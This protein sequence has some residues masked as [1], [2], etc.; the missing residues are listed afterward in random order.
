[1]L[2]AEHLADQAL[3]K[4]PFYYHAKFAALLWLQLPQTRGAAYLYNRFYKP[5]LVQ[6]GPHIDAVLAKG[7]NLLANLYAMYKVPIE[8]AV[9]LG[10][11]AW[12]SLVAAVKALSEEKKAAGDKKGDAVKPHAA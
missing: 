9:A 5:A 2:L 10:L 8:A 1:M 12:K 6:Y 3:G 4:V 7:H 11:Q